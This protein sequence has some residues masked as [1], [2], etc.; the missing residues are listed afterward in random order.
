MKTLA[1]A[2]VLSAPLVLRTGAS[3]PPAAAESPPRS[4]G[5]LLEQEAAGQRAHDN[6]MVLAFISIADFLRAFVERSQQAVQYDGS[7][8]VCMAT[9]NA[10]GREFCASK[11]ISLHTGDDGDVVYRGVTHSTSL[12]DLVRAGFLRM[13]FQRP[14]LPPRHRVGVFDEQGV[15]TDIVSMSNVVEWVHLHVD[16]LGTLARRTLAE[17]G[18]AGAAR[19]ADMPP[20]EDV[21]TVPTT[22]PTGLCFGVLVHRGV[23]AVGVVDAASGVLVANLSESDFRAFG[24]DDF[25][26]LALPVGEYL[27]H[28]R[29]LSVSARDEAVGEHAV[30]GGGGGGGAA[31]GPDAICDPW[32]RALHAGGAAITLQPDATLMRAL[33]TLIGCRV[34]RVYVVDPATQ[35]PLSV[36]SHTDILGTL[37][38]G[39]KPSA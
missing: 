27:L 34:H 22:M 18:L 29:N 7:L 26:G 6:Y 17:L 23:S 24:P 1:A 11:V 39:H 30:G 15:V 21:V 37:L 8:L 5:A 14:P 36:V 33:E 12:V 16:K 10:L 20:S 31:R 2:H 4:G 28:K 19:T 32:A 9:L 13:P 35:A 3:S 25:G 38:R